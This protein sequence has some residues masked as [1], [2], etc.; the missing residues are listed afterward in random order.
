M[1][2]SEL[3]LF[4]SIAHTLNFSKTAEQFYISQPAVSY[5]LKQLEHD[6]GVKLIERTSHQVSVTHA[7]TEFLEY[8]TRILD[9]ADLSEARMKS[10]AEGRT[11][12][13][14]IAALPSTSRE[15]TQ[16]LTEFA[17]QYPSIQV[18]VNLLEGA[19]MVRALKQD[20]YNIY[21]ATDKMIPVGENYESFFLHSY[22]HYLFMSEKFAP[23][24]DENDWS[25]ISHLPF[26]S[27]LRRDNA[28][29]SQSRAICHNRNIRYNIINYHNRADSVL[30]SVSAGIGLAILPM[31]FVDFTSNMPIA[32]FPINGEDS[33]VDFVVTYSKASSSQAMENF[34]EVT[35]SLYNG[36]QPHE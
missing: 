9:L 1:E 6:L 10:L 29:F 31:P 36:T 13:I 14:K 18:D 27:V 35:C 11:G 34:K 25:S 12:R 33:R 2:L 19:D 16:C 32:A 15:L 20:S 26:V 5:K 28:L 22:Q 8:A 4:I 3:R 21:F 17:Q 24:Y 7:G 30:I 23:L